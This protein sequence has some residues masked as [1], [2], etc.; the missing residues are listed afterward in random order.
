MQKDQVPS[1]CWRVRVIEQGFRTRHV[2]PELVSYL[3]K[4]KVRVVRFRRGV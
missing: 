1:A 2:W 4:V 3:G